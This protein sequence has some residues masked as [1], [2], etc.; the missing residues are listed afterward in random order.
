MAYSSVRGG[1]DIGVAATRF[2]TL[3]MVASVLFFIREETKMKDSVTI[4]FDDEVR[5]I[6]G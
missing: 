3:A 1:S 2:G 5:F 6:Q 4:M